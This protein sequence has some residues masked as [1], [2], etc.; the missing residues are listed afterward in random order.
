MIGAGEEQAIRKATSAD[1]EALTDIYNHYVVNSHHT[2]DMT[3]FSIDGRRPWFERFATNGPHRLL[4]ATSGTD[5]V[6]YASSGPHRPKPGYRTSVETTVYLAP[7][8]TGQGLGTRLYTALFDALAGQQLH[9]ALAGIALPN[10]ASI[11]LHER[12]GFRHV[13]TFTEQGTKFDRYWDVA[14]F[15]KPLGG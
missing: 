12:F 10:D 1:L 5:V 7:G 14:W 9:R 11:A 3:P 13:G 8:A 4:V 2:F 15:E 6:G